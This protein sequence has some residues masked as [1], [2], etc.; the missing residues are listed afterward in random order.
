MTDETLV[1]TKPEAVKRH[2]LGLKEI[3]RAGTATKLPIAEIAIGERLIPEDPK[4]VAQLVISMEQARQLTPVLVRRT[5]AG[6]HILVDGL[7]KISALKQL[8]KTEVLA[9]VLDVASDE[10]AKACEAI[11]NSHRRQKLT[12]LDRALTDVAFLQYVEK[13]VSQDATP[14]GGRQLKE[15]FHAKTA[16]EL[17][18]SPDQIARSCKIA[19]IDPYVQNAV[20]RYKQEDNQ[21]L[22]LEVAA[23]GDDVTAQIYTLTRL[24]GKAGK[25]AKKARADKPFEPEEVEAQ[26][27]PPLQP[28]SS[29]PDSS[30]GDSAAGET[31]S[32]T[33][34]IETEDHPLA[35]SSAQSPLIS[36]ETPGASK[37]DFIKREWVDA[38]ALRRIL[39]EATHHDRRRFID[40]CVL[41]EL[42]PSSA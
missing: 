36:T 25:A 32:S 34:S 35:S 42:F 21:K 17:G 9:S 14:R 27:R 30:P 6:G 20:R 23:S 18:V 3:S 41:P 1:V 5:P 28:Q 33:H 19:K 8:S 31:Q 2:V 22:L 37:F 39:R 29:S 15:K 16:R 7:N 11:S 12:A 38:K 26:T 24:M 13:K 4:V 40:E 10:E